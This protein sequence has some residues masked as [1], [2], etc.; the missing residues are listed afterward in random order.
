MEEKHKFV[1]AKNTHLTEFLDKEFKKIQEHGIQIEKMVSK[2]KKL[3][4]L[5]NITAK[6]EASNHKL[7]D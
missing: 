2:I 7:Q 5:F 6:E 1:I 4:E 3:K